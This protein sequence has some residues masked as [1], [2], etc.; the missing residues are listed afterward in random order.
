V[1]VSADGKIYNVTMRANANWDDGTPV[2]SDDVIFTLS[3]LRSQASAFS[4]DVHSLWEGV[5]VTRLKRLKISK[6]VLTEPFVPFLD[7]LTFGHPAEAFAGV[8]VCD[9]LA[10]KRI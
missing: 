9:Q 1:G 10:T 8:G 4:P 6:F 2:T 7:Y 5:Q 3:L